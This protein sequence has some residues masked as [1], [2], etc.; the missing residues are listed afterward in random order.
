LSE[1]NLLDAQL[2]GTELEGID[3]TGAVMPDGRR[4]RL[5][6]RLKRFTG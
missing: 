1:T 6:T 4:K 2:E 5:F 3:L